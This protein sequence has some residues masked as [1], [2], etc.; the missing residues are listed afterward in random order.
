MTSPAADPAPLTHPARNDDTIVALSSAGAASAPSGVAGLPAL[1]RAILRLSGP[2]A[3]ELAA[4]L[5]APFPTPD[6]LDAP[7]RWHR[8]TGTAAG[9][10]AVAYRMPA[11]RSYTRQD[12]AEVHLPAVAPCLAG[13]LDTL[14]RAG[15]RA[16]LP[17]EFTRRALR[18]GRVTLA[19]AEAIGALVR[20]GDAD[21]ARAQA[22][23]AAGRTAS[24]R[25]KLRAEIE[26]LLA[27]VELNLDFSHEDVETL[28][29]AELLAR[30]K[31][32]AEE[33][34][35]EAGEGGGEAL[36]S[37]GEVRAVLLGATHAGKS[38]LFNALL[39]RDEA[40][41][42][43][44]RHTTRDVVEASCALEDALSVRLLDTAGLGAIGALEG[45]EAGALSPGARLLALA[46]DATAKAARA[47]DVLLV[48]VESHAGFEAEL[49]ALCALAKET[50]PA[51]AALLFTK[52][53]LPRPE[54]WAAQAAAVRAKLAEALQTDANTLCV[55]EVSA[56]SGAGLNELRAFLAAQAKALRAR[57]SA[58]R[59][60]AR[61]SAR[62]A[63]RA[64]AEA[65][66][67]AAAA[68]EGGLGED[69]AVVELREA[70]HALSEAGGVLLRHDALTEALLDRIFHDFCIGK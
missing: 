5:F 53:D 68:V 1:P 8:A 33:A 60:A 57:L 23:Q 36:L 40:L 6:E 21:A 11:P 12:V 16:A 63:S 70:V 41:V 4:L 50:R 14:L 30:L 51:A 58:A 7:E 54:G 42:A 34:R 22:A 15:A 13:C 18:N 24:Q 55:L 19:Q 38:S 48:A 67:R 25:A 27:L 52:R 65:L 44:S 3:F 64:A 29:R 10:P 46:Q 37:L 62:E 49:H 17:G 43:D 59:A 45:S 35:A 69:A 9:L 47:A 31:T 20:A 61:A 66:A 39:G 26:Q 2:R 28:P 56:K 32:L